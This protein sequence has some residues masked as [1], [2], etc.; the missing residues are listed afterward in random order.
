MNYMKHDKP[1]SAA[2][3]QGERLVALLDS[4]GF[5]ETVWEKAKLHLA[6]TFD[7]EDLADIFP[8]DR[9]DELLTSGS[10]MAPHLD[11]VSGGK[12]NAAPFLPSPSPATDVQ[13]VLTEMGNGATVRIPH[14]E[15]Y[16]QGV[17]EFA[18]ALEA[19]F[20]MPIR[21]NL[22]LTPPF[23]QGFQPHYDLDDIVVVQV[24]GSK[25]WSLHRDYA[26]QQPLPNGDMNFQAQRHRPAGVPEQ[27]ELRA[28]DVMY[29]PRGFMH[30]A[31][32]DADWSIHITFAFIGVKVGDLLQQLIRL[33][34]TRSPELRRTIAFDPAQEPDGEALAALA[35]TLRE[36][37]EAALR[38]EAIAEAAALMRKTMKGHRNPFL[39]GQILEKLL[40]GEP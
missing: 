7:S 8:L 33:A 36:Q 28:G 26:N 34:A 31:R 6:A 16:M 14:I 40:N 9:F 24:L 4:R 15:N 32:T 20:H 13:R 29:L 11:I 3:R 38:P 10:V 5:A 27:L 2:R 12:K 21:A 19:R 1:V 22:Y 30:E 23:N 17:G 35:A 37:V 25:T 39:R 18:R